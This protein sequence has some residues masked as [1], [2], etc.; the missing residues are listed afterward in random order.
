[1]TFID[2]RPIARFSFFIS[3]I[4]LFNTSISCSM[5]GSND[6]IDSLF[7]ITNHLTHRYD[8]S[9]PDRT[10]LMPGKLKE[11]SG[12]SYV[13][14]QSLIC[15]EDETG[16]LYHF[17]LQSGEVD[18]DW[19]FS[20]DGDYEDLEIVND[21]LYILKSDGDIYK[22]HY[23][24]EGAHESMKYETR[25]SA[26]HDTEGLG[27]DPVSKSLL[28][29][30][31]EEWDLEGKEA[32]G[33]AIYAFSTIDN[34]LIHEPKYILTARSLKSFFEQNRDYTYEAARIRIK[35]SGIAFNPLDGYFYILASVGKMI[36]VLDNK[37]NI[38]ATY[39]IPNQ[40]MEQPEG[41]TFSPEG[42]LWIS[43]EG[44]KGPGKILAYKPVTRQ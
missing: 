28:I 8:L 1:M 4:M 25:L 3:I 33:T 18:S 35:P 6:R 31:K 26:K 12:I 41:I 20:G 16:H 11:I 36:I 40:L 42:D 43:T 21:T 7:T 34:R 22:F 27:Y 44:G 38:K 2:K 24:K 17:N 9:A 10:Y 13:N 37:Y 15:V 14:E 29:A 32:E 30:C 23:S 39:S 5:H 19:R